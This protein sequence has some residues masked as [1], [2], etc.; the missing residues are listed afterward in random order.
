MPQRTQGHKGAGGAGWCAHALPPSPA[1]ALA[2][3]V[4]PVPGGPMSSTP[5]GGRAPSAVKRS[6]SRRNSTTCSQC[7]FQVGGWVGG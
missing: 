1:T 3:R 2:S 5:Q 4:L 7:A 6:G